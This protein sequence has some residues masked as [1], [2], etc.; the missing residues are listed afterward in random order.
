MICH[1]KVCRMS[2]PTVETAIKR[3]KHIASKSAATNAMLLSVSFYVIFTTLPATLVYVLST[4]FPEGSYCSPDMSADPTWRSHVVYFIVRKIVDEICMSHYA[5]NFFLFVITGL[6]FRLELCRTLRR[7]RSQ[8]GP[9]TKSLCENGHS[10]NS[11]MYRNSLK[12]AD[13][14]QTCVSRV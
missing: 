7:F 10:E 8:P 4:V 3:H 12:S 11:R 5:C 2:N 13:E 6:E 14:L 9:T 1:V